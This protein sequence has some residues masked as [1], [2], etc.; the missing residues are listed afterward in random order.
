MIHQLNIHGKD[1][2][3]VAID[4]LKAF[5]PPEG[6]YLAFSGGKDSVVIKALADMA[7]VKYDA[8]YNITSVD[9][10]ELVQFIKKF[11]DV[12]IDKPRDKN[13]KQ[14]TMWNLIPKKRYPPTRIARYCC[15]ALK[16]EQSNGRMT[17]T[18]VRW[19]ES[20][21]RKRNQG[22]VT[23][24]KGKKHSLDRLVES[25]NFTATPRGGVVLNNDNEESRKMVEQCY[26]LSTTVI[27]P[28]I[29]WSN[30]DVWEFIR[31]Y[32]IPYCKLYDEG[33]KRLGCIGC[34]MGNNKA[35]LEKYPKYKQAYIRAFERMLKEGREAGVDYDKWETGED[36]YKWWVEW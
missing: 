17:I 27:N 21:N 12:Q 14:I 30:E 16:E 2:V 5:E 7:K 24:M 18:G 25:G 23:I 29:D 3:Q 6:Y 26:K 11:E 1:K 36:V 15:Q 22:E 10:P 19:A 31:E 34:P 8:H 13:G 9:P 33:Y 35:E 28:I 20:A 32:N 4:R